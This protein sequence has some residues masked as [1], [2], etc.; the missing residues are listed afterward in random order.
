MKLKSKFITQTIDDMQY[1][2]S[3]DGPFKGVVRSNETAGFIIRQLEND[4]TVDNI[5]E[6]LLAEYDAPKDLLYADV[7]K[8]LNALRK[9]NALDE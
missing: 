3:M 1:L 2:V 9:I 7:N 8:V 5:V 4:T 6:A